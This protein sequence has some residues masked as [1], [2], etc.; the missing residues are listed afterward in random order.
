M[1]CGNAERN[2]DI[3]SLSRFVFLS[4]VVLLASRWCAPMNEPRRLTDI[5]LLFIWVFGYH[6]LIGGFS[7]LQGMEKLL[8]GPKHD[9]KVDGARS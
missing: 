9:P 6:V 4:F 8:A 2:E 1:S 3:G 7:A 5:V